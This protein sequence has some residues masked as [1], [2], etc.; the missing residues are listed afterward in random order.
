[1]STFL[2]TSLVL[3]LVLVPWS[4]A[5]EKAPETVK[6]AKVVLTG[7]VITDKEHSFVLTQV[8]ELSGPASTTTSTATPAA[9]SG[10]KDGGPNEVIYWLS[11]DSIK[12]MRGHLG[13]KVEVAGVITDVSMGTVRTKQEPGKKGPDNKV[14]VEARGKESTV[15]TDKPVG[16]GAPALVKSDQTQSLPVRRVKVDTVRMIAATCS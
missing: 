3:S 6:G 11:E 16:S 10:M 13:H 15:E 8:E 12:L 2:S 14:E 5:D 1:M 4:A 9:M 7:C